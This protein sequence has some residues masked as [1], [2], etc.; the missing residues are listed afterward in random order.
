M[1]PANPYDEV[2]YP[3]LT[4]A[5][6][7]P[8]RLAVTA[9]L[10]GM[11]PAPPDRCRVL[12]LG[13]GSGANLIAMAEWLPESRFTGID[14]SRRQVGAGRAT[15]RALGLSNV[16]LRRADIARLPDDLGEFD[17]VIVHGVFSWV[18]AG[19]RA[20]ILSIIRRSLAPDGVAYVSYNAYPGWHSLMAVREIMLYR[21]RA[22]GD[23]RERVEKAKEVVDF[24]ARASSPEAGAFGAFLHAYRRALVERGELPE[25]DIA[26][27]LLHDELAPTNDPLYFHEFASML[28]ANGLQYLAEADL[29]GATSLGLAPG[30]VEGL[31]KLAGNLIEAEQYMDFVRNQTFRRT[32]IAHAGAPIARRQRADASSLREVQVA[33]FA[34]P[35][36]GAAGRVTLAGPD[37]REFST[38]HFLTQQAF[39]ILRRVYPAALPFPELAAGAAVAPAR[40]PETGAPPGQSD[41]DALAGNLLSAF[42]YSRSLVE[43]YL[44]PVPV[45]PR[46]LVRP[47]VSAFARRLAREGRELM[48]NLRHER[49][50][51][52][53]LTLRLLPLLDGRA[54][55]GDLR[56]R[57]LELVR[58]AG[59]G[60]PLEADA[61][62]QVR[63]SL[64]WLARAAMLRGRKLI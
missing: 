37:R 51:L 16:S 7:H 59:A 62:R 30:V 31:A 6:T 49:V 60:A 25:S 18:P 20:R 28:E 34:R 39:S 26:A 63:R 52:D 11:R 40:I 38:D 14:Y 9:K 27:S 54:S 45:A 17:Y 4:H 47:R 3:D 29:A 21:L 24:L 61:W 33:S 58:A 36:R 48:P 8:D 55:L 13:C 5:A 41:V 35:L 32:L 19:I 57:A 2:P 64:W 43:L 10:L 1:A 46:P 50:R 22:L 15:A 12:E 56:L 23:P 44:R 53:P 42:A